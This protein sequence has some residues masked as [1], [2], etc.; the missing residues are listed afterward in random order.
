[1][2]APP[3]NPQTPDVTALNT[4]VTA[5]GVTTG[6]AAGEQWGGGPTG[7]HAVV[8]SYTINSSGTMTSQTPLDLQT[9]LPVGHRLSDALNFSGSSS[10]S[11]QGL[12]INSSGTVVVGA[13]ENALLGGPNS[14]TNYL[15]YNMTAQTFTPLTDST[16]G[17][18]SMMY[19]PIASTSSELDAG[20]D[21][22]I[23]NAG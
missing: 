9:S 6:Q 15:L 5:G 4:P 1:M 17:Q 19:E 23:N 22:A 20:H 11:S 21:Q 18:I 10:L 7:N 2:N 12:A 3:D 16:S 14:D 8:W 13:R